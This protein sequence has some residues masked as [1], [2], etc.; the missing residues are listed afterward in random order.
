MVA[1]HFITTRATASGWVIARNGDTIDPLDDPHAVAYPP[2]A[3][4]ELPEFD[5]EEPLPEEGDFWIEPDDDDS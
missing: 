5:D 2:H 3:P 1:T 4:W